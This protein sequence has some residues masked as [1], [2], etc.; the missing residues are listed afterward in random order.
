VFGDGAAAAALGTA[1]GYQANAGGANSVAMGYLASSGAVNNIA[2]G[3][4]AIINSSATP[5]IVIGAAVA[6]TSSAAYGVSI[7]QGNTLN[8]RAVIIGHAISSGGF[9]DSFATGNNALVRA[10]GDVVFSSNGAAGT[11]RLQYQSSTATTRDN[12]SIGVVAVDNTDASRKYRAVFSAF[13]TAA[14]ECM[15]IEASGTVAMMGFFGVAAVVR[16]TALTAADAG[17]INT[18][19]AGTDTVIGNMRTRIGELETK[20][21]ALGLLT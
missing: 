8:S 6:T 2:I 4:Q 15:R 10:A 16:P 17:A 14:R 20:L 11:L 5:C 3:Q 13:D 21:Q 18:G 12:F 19:D 1:V 7:G 9:N